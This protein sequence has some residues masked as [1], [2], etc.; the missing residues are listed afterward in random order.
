MK[1]IRLLRKEG[2]DVNM[3]Q[4]HLERAYMHIIS[5]SVPAGCRTISSAFVLLSVVA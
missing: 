4:V 1:L 5:V 3:W 2:S